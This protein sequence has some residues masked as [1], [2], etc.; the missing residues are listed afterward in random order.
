M[1]KCGRRLRSPA[2]SECCKDVNEGIHQ[3]GWARLERS[4]SKV[5]DEGKAEL[6]EKV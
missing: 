6:R 4:T 2:A 3:E 5:G 1:N